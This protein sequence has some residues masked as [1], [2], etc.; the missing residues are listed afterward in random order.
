M[1]SRSPTGYARMPIVRLAK[2]LRS[3]V[4]AAE[5]DVPGATVREALDVVFARCPALRGY[6]L[7]DQGA[8]R[9]HVAIFAN[10]ETLNDRETLSDVIAA[11]T[12][13]YLMQALSGG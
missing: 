13:I 1:D 10:N 5:F 11:N 7:D 4:S 6:V 2:H 9:K 8:V 3:H 12:E